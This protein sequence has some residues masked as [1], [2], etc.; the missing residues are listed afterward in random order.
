MTG[1]C[2]TCC[3]S[4]SCP[5]V[6]TGHNP[7]YPGND[8]HVLIQGMTVGRHGVKT[9]NFVKVFLLL[10][11]FGHTLIFKHTHGNKLMN[12]LNE[13]LAVI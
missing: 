12:K 2:N 4:T 10:C 11:V 7:R 5:P 13:R 8:R 6:G 3:R 9:L 1:P